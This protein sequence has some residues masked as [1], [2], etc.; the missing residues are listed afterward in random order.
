M[1]NQ[2]TNKYYFINNFDQ[3][4]INK[5][6]KATTIIYRNYGQNT[7]KELILKLKNYC[8]IRGNKFL[9]ANN[10]R[11]AIQLNLDG[12][13]IPSFNKNNKH[14]SY[15]FRKKFILIGSAHNIKEIRNKELQNV[16]AIVLSSL[17][18][19]N[20]NYLGLRRFKLLS[21]LTDKKII[22]LGGVSRKNLKQLNLI[23][24]FDFAGISFFR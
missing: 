3:N 10:I 12:A 6:D 21:H 18:K 5:Q 14:L 8:K 15:S 1:H 24:C 19:K 4:H 13:Y 20:K 17:H 9:I 22:A 23:S 2:L 11:L 16:E 7:D